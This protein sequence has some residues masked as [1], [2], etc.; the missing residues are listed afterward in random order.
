M[1]FVKTHPPYNIISVE[2]LESVKLLLGDWR[3][4]CSVSSVLLSW[5]GWKVGLWHQ[6][7]GY[8]GH[9]LQGTQGSCQIISQVLK[10]CWGKQLWSGS[11]ACW[12]NNISVTLVSFRGSVVYFTLKLGTY[13]HTTRLKSRVLFLNL[14]GMAATPFLCRGVWFSLNKSY[15][16]IVS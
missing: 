13:L 9:A 6:G 16:R 2:M 7:V 3:Q 12:K 4:D 15:H 10:R 11:F 5:L 8:G 14:F 1:N